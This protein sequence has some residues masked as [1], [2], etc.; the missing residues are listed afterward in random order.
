MAVGRTG[1]GRTWPAV[2]VVAATL[3]AC[4][5]R[6]ASTPFADGGEDYD[7]PVE[8]DNHN[9]LDIVVFALQGEAT[10]RLGSVSGLSSSSLNVPGQL[11]VLGRIRLLV[12]PVGS[13]EAYLTE[14]IMVNPGDV[15]VLQVGSAIRQSSWS[16]R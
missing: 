4:A 13:R 5:G 15:V 11:V 3:S 12:D 8:V 7:I 6:S 14:D 16:V 9:Y 1:I 2:L 10:T